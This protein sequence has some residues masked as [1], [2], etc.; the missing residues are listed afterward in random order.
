MAAL[1]SAL[2]ITAEQPLKVKWNLE[3]H[4]PSPAEAV[5]CLTPTLI[6]TSHRGLATFHVS[7]LLS[8]NLIHVS[9]Y[10]H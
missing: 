2:L 6:H 5:L 4:V 10:S 9:V 3:G 7:S 1:L 8:V